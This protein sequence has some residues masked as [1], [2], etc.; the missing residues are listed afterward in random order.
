MQVTLNG[1][2]S[3]NGVQDEPISNI[4]QPF[5]WAADIHPYTP[6]IISDSDSFFK[7]DDR[8]MERLYTFRTRTMLHTVGPKG[9][10]LWEREMTNLTCS[11]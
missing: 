8:S 2:A 6:P 10:E 4:D 1:A 7:F 9:A 11:V 5:Y 3:I